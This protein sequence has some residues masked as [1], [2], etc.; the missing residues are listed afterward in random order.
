M[1]ESEQDNY[2]NDLLVKYLAGE[3]ALA[4]IVQVEEWLNADEANHLYYAQFKRIWDESLL[5]AANSTVDEDAAYNRLQRRIKNS[6]EKSV[7]EEATITPIQKKRT[8]WLAIAA[9]FIAIC[10][11][12]YFA[13]SYFTGPPKMITLASNDKVLTD[14]LPDGSVI[15]MNESSAINYPEN[16]KGNI[17]EVKLTGE[18]FFNVTPDKTKPFIIKV[19]DVTVRVVGTSFNIKS[20][21]GKT[22][23][24][25][26]TGIV[27]VKKAGNQINLKPGERTETDNSR[28][29]L[30]KQNIKGKLYNYYASHELVC[31]QTPLT[32]LVQALNSIYGANIVIGNKKIEDLP[33]TT[34]FKDQSL[35]QVLMVVSET[36][37]IKVERDGRKIVLK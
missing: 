19:N 33:I 27:N 13:V 12:S 7:T 17:R 16:F 26:E 32:E 11:L 31:D 2:M 10:T 9:S 23:V 24:I 21:G 35:S 29:D 25:V 4:E 1:S 36:F 30:T 3:A 8:N 28:D 34:V 22:E 18:A 37:K 15:T 5:V 20:R 6:Q 14:T